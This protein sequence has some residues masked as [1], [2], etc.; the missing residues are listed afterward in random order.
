MWKGR[1]NDSTCPS[2]MFTEHDPSRRVGAEAVTKSSLP[3]PDQI[4]CNAS[5]DQRGLASPLFNC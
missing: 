2:H 4:Y 3:L 5:S 1:C